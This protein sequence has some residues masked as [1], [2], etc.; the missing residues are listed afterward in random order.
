MRALV[1]ADLMTPEVLAVGLDTTIPELAT[2]L[3]DNEVTGAVVKSEKGH[4]VGVVSFT[5]IAAAAE[6]D[7]A[8]EGTEEAAGFYV[9]TRDAGTADAPPMSKHLESVPVSEIMT[10]RL[11]FVAPST[12]VSEVAAT[13]LDLRLHRLLVIDQDELVGIISTSD[14]IGLLVESA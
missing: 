1:A 3:L 10:P 12:P 14:L 11:H 6:S 9:R 7:L 2:F 4:P 13:L 5:D 8:R